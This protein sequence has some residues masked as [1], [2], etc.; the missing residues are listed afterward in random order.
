MWKYTNKTLVGACASSLRFA[1]AR[2]RRRPPAPLMPSIGPELTRRDAPT[3]SLQATGSRTATRRRLWTPRRGS[4]PRPPPASTYETSSSAIGVAAEVPAVPAPSSLCS[5]PSISSRRTP[6]GPPAV[7]PSAAT[8][9]SSPAPSRPSPPTRR[10]TRDSAHS[11][12]RRTRAS[13][14]SRR[15]TT[16]PSGGTPRESTPRDRTS[17][18]RDCAPSSAST[19]LEGFLGRRFQTGH[20]NGRGRSGAR[21]PL[22]RHAEECGARNAS[23]VWADEYAEGR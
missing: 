22:T 4:P 18:A 11:T 9:P 5:R 17:P 12:P 3:L 7:R 8:T 13:S 6:L 23:S 20:Q 19:P 1:F 16:E 15:T 21:G 10:P 2:S 14:P